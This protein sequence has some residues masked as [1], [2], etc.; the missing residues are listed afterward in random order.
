MALCT[1]RCCPYEPFDAS[2]AS[3]TLMELPLLVKPFE[4]NLEGDPFIWA[5]IKFVSYC[6]RSPTLSPK[7]ACPFLSIP[8]YGP[9]SSL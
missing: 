4:T 2:L 9:C 3:A 7:T 6:E 1:P 5:K 8:P